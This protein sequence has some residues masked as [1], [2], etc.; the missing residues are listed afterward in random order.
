MAETAIPDFPWETIIKNI[1]EGRC[2]PFLGA[3]VNVKGLDNCDGLP[4]GGDVALRLLEVLL[5][6][7]NILPE[8]RNPINHKNLRY[9][10]E[11]TEAAKREFDSM[12]PADALQAVKDRFDEILKTILPRE[13]EL[14]HIITHE[15]LEQYKELT[16]IGFQDL[17]RVSLRYR[18]DTDLENFVDKL[19]EIIPDVERKPSKLLTT[20]SKLPFKLIVTTNYDRLMERAFEL[21]EETDIQDPVQMAGKI[22]PNNDLIPSVIYKLLS[23]NM[24]KLLNESDKDNYP[25]P[26]LWTDE[27]NRI[28]QETSLYELKEISLHGDVVTDELIDQL[29]EEIDNRP[30]SNEGVRKNREVL[31]Q[32]FSE[33]IKPHKRSYEVLVQPIHGFKGAD[34]N[35]ARKA[36]SESDSVI[37]YKLHGSFSDAKPTKDSRPVVTEEDYIEFLTFVGANGEGIDNQIKEKIKDSTLLFL[38]YSLEDWNFRALFKGLVEKVT[39]EERPLSYAIQKEPSE[40]WKD[41]WREK[42]VRIFDVDLQVFANELEKQFQEYKKEADKRARQIEEEKEKRREERRRTRRV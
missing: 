20:L 18:M 42:S 35:D 15:A 40:F 39:P 2:V 11:K 1:Y 37:L 34:E 28:I 31:E 10:I 3:G 16:R 5:R 8:L 12:T 19:K 13:Q 36:L 14:A 7:R 29:I 22:K 41:F 33:E 27:L 6:R 32:A 9:Y 25:G 26:Q 23:E 38:G 30:K 17:A 4:L 24:K 21:I